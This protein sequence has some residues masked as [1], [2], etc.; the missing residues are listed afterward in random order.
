M[1]YEVDQANDD[2]DSKLVWNIAALV[3]ASLFV[4]LML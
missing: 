4:C 1:S 2:E 3:V